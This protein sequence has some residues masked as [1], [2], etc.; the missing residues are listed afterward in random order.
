MAVRWRDWRLYRKYEKDAWQLFDLKSDP[1]EEQNVADAHPDVVK[2]MS[3]K[4]AAWSQTLSPLGKIPE[5]KQ[6]TT[7]IPN[8]H[9]WAQ[10]KTQGSAK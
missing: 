1:R 4:H 2:Q 6:R 8:G 3:E 7:L 10:A 9:G 5:I